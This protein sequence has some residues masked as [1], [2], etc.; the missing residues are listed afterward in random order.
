MIDDE[1]SSVDDGY[2]ADGHYKDVEKQLYKTEQQHVDPSRNE[3]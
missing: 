2:D 1:G 3:R